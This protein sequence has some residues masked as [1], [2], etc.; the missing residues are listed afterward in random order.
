VIFYSMSLSAD[1]YIAGPDGSFD[2]AVPSQELHRFHNERVAAIDAQLLGR[3]LYETMLVWDTEEF[4]DPVMAEFA[5]IWRPL[6]KIVFSTTLTSVEGSNRLATGTL[7]EEIAA[8]GDRRIAV[9]GAGLAAECMRRGLIDEFELLSSRSSSVAARRTSRR[10]CTSTSSWSRP[11]PSARPCTC[12]TAGA[13]RG[14][15][16]RSTGRPRWG[17]SAAR[18][19]RQ[20]GHHAAQLPADLSRSRFRESRLN[21]APRRPAGPLARPHNLRRCC[22]G[23][24]A[25]AAITSYVSTGE[26]GYQAQP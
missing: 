19:G 14:S 4:A 17:S 8:L 5:E 21:R 11:A 13:A 6:E 24:S 20:M 23:G 26:F 3:R 22:R 25:E 1:G 2:W 9:G 12:T 18:L 7:E 16:T 15:T 10:T